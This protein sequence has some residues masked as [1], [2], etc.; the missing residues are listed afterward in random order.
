MCF[1]IA[2]QAG[3]DEE[4]NVL[5]S[6]QDA[7]MLDENFHCSH[8]WYFSAKARL[9]PAK[10]WK[11]VCRSWERM[12]WHC[13]SHSVCMLW[14]RLHQTWF[15]VYFFQGL[16][17]WWWTYLALL[18][19]MLAA[20]ESCQSPWTSG[21]HI[22][23]NIA[24]KTTAQPVTHTASHYY[25][26]PCWDSHNAVRHQPE[27]ISLLLVQRGSLLWKSRKSQRM[28]IFFKDVT[29]IILNPPVS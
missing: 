14:L 6:A 13:L 5:N 25:K 4:A 2:P 21:D 24:L 18:S 16:C 11:D 22:W 26:N 28:V 7:W 23:G 12:H 3:S 29:N 9:A 8:T 20:H 19:Q 27:Q 1:D 15:R 17:A 10:T